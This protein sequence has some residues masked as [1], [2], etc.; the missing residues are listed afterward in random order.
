MIPSD[1]SRS[2]KSSE[3]PEVRCI[4][5]ERRMLVP[6]ERTIEQDDSDLICLSCRALSP[7][8]RRVLRTQA[9]TRIL[10]RATNP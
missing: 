10:R 7:E 9:M 3:S 6:S 8:E 2:K 4:L 1:A 5:C